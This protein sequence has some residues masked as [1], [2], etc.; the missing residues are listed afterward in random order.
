MAKYSKHYIGV[1]ADFSELLLDDSDPRHATVQR[2]NPR[3]WR[4]VMVF[5]DGTGK[6]VMR[7]V[8][9][10]NSK[11]DALLIDRFVSERYY[12]KTNFEAFRAANE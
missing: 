8:G 2:F 1:H 7:H 6:E 11:E 4:P 12:L 5:L 10:V 3:K 9:R